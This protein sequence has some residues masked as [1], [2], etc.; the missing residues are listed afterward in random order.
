MENTKSR[1]SILKQVFSS[2]KDIFLGAEENNNGLLTMSDL[3]SEDWKL[4]SDA[5]KKEILMKSPERIKEIFSKIFTKVLSKKEKKENSKD[6]VVNENKN[7]K[8]KLMREFHSSTIPN[9]VEV[10]D[11]DFAWKKPERKEEDLEKQ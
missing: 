8:L 9:G 11:S 2:L 3:K 7:I 1:D 10:G 5:D 6:E 4:V